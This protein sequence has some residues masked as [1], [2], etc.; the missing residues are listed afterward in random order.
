[1]SRDITRADLL[2]ALRS[3]EDVEEQLRAIRRDGGDTS[4]QEVSE[5]RRQLSGARQDIIEYHLTQALDNEPGSVEPTL[6]L[7]PDVPVSRPRR[8]FGE[9]L[10]ETIDRTGGSE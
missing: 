6:D 9:K 7:E 3:V 2:D 5:I 4:E 8:G 10:G 1:M